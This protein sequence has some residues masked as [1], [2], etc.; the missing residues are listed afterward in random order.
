MSAW[1]KTICYLSYLQSERDHFSFWLIVLEVTPDLS[2][3]F[4]IREWVQDRVSDAIRSSRGGP[5]FF[6]RLSGYR[7]TDF[8]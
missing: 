6:G 3:L 2:H 1:Y 8:R 5:S 7:Q 4:S